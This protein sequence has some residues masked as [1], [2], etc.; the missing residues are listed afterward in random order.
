MKD[1]T[2]DNQVATLEWEGREALVRIEK[3]VPSDPAQPV[4]EA[5]FEHRIA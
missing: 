5:V 4:L 3:A 2:F 1:P